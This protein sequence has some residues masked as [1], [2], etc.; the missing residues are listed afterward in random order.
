[1]TDFEIRALT[2][3]DWRDYRALRLAALADAPYAFGSTLAREQPFED[4]RWRQRLSSGVTL[5]AFVDSEASGLAG[6][7]R[8][9]V[10][11]DDA[12]PE[13]A[14]LVQMWV[15]PSSRG[16]GI[17][18]ALVERVIE[19]ARAQGYPE[20]RLTVSEGNDNAERLYTRLGFVRTG[21]VLPIR[22]GETQLEATMLLRL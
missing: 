3:E 4:D 12:H 17:G 22:P 20:L 21:D 14:Y 16:R 1:M 18:A 7:L 11:G 10:Y 5:C 6:G 19:W 15:H 2:V 8:P 13:A 9:G